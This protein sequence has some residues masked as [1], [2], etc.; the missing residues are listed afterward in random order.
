MVGSAPARLIVPLTP[1]RKAIPCSPGVALASVIAWR[2]EP[3]PALAV[4]VTTR[5]SGWRS[6]APAS[7][8]SPPAAFV[9][10]GRSTGRGRSRWSRSIPGAASPL[11]IAGLVDSSAIVC[12]GP[13]LPCSGPR[14]GS[15][16]GWSVASPKPQLLADSTLKPCEV[17]PP[18]QLALP[19]S[20]PATIVLRTFTGPP[21]F[22][23]T[24]AVPATS[25]FVLPAIVLLSRVVVPAKARMPPATVV[26]LAV[27]PATV[28]FCTVVVPAAS[29]PPPRKSQCCRRS[30]CR[31]RSVSRWC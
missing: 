14:T 27:L 7:V 19:P 26:P 31:A 3:G 15:V 1:G 6:T 2:S 24:L 30:C 8:P 25:V 5:G 28:L 10:L 9:L 11:S 23:R 16:P 20:G 17:I 4:V 21:P 22:R 18:E 29:I 12:V 13:R